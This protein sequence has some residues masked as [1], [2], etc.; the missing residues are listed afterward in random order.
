[1]T[2]ED[3]GGDKIQNY[4]V[5]PEVINSSFEKI[6]PHVAI[7]QLVDFIKQKTHESQKV[8]NILFNIK[9]QKHF[10]I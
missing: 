1:M 2:E 3:G 8:S 9:L 6:E 10:Q 4:V 5:L 7:K